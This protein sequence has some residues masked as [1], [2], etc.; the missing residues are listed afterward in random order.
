MYSS[1]PGAGSASGGGSICS[2][3]NTA[4]Q[5]LILAECGTFGSGIS[6]NPADGLF[7]L[8]SRWKWNVFLE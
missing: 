8:Q 7:W 4:P 6:N 2:Q 3:L 5:S 1:T